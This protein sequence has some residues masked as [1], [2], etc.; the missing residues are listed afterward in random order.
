[1]LKTKGLFLAVLTAGTVFQLGLGGCGPL[2]L[3]ALG[4]GG[5]FVLTGGLP[6]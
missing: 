3:A 2:G 4:L 5:L 6:Q 1:M